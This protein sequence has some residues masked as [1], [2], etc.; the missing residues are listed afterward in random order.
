M[1]KTTMKGFCLLVLLIVFASCEKIKPPQTE[2]CI[3]GD[4]GLI[5]NDPRLETP[6]YILLFEQ[7]KNYVCVSP[8]SYSVLYNWTDK[9]VEALEKCLNNPKKCS[10]TD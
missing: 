4:S 9:V 7:S 2:Q 1:L 3:F 6:D 8:T 5:C 10:Y